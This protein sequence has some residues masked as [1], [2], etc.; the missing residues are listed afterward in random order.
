M[1]T[2]IKIPHLATEESPRVI[3]ATHFKSIGELP[4]RGGWGY[5][6]DDAVIIDRNDPI[7]Q[8]GI[9]FNGIGIEYVFV[10]KRIYEEL[11]I[12]CR[13]DDRHS[14]IKWEQLRQSLHEYDGKMY[15]KLTYEV[16]ALPDKDW[17]ELKAEWEGPN[18]HGSSNFD[19]D[20]H[21]KKRF[22]RT[23]RYIAEYWFDITSFY[24]LSAE[25]LLSLCK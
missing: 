11:I 13:E 19:N 17:N 7:V 22:S 5:T 8:K 12:F 2:D 24:G 9:P 15:D 3:L 18:G 14:G 25:D 4:I 23:V 10:E 6:L 16:T 20:A 21:V 1:P